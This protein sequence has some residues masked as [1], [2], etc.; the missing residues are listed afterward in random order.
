MTSYCTRCGAAL[1]DGDEFC[2]GCGS[3]VKDRAAQPAQA[4]RH[5]QAVV[6]PPRQAPSPQRS[7]AAARASTTPPRASAL[8]PSAPQP[9]SDSRPRFPPLLVAVV[10]ALGVA[11][12]LDV[13]SML[14]SLVQDIDRNM[15][16]NK[17]SAWDTP[18][19][20]HANA[21]HAGGLGLVWG[22]ILGGAWG[23]VKLTRD[24]RRAA[25]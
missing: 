2:G 16:F 12:G 4:V 14:G 7:D 25:R 22:L 3:P 15:A 1:T 21:V 6:H 24:R 8:P 17:W 11:L 23:W 19:A 18:Q 13:L 20:L 10:R 5:P 9:P